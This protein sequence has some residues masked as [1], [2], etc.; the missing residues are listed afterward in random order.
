[1]IDTQKQ[2]E[3]ALQRL[4]TV[5]YGEKANITIT[6][7]P[8]RS[9]GTFAGYIIELENLPDDFTANTPDWNRDNRLNYIINAIDDTRLQA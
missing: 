7:K 5:L 4:M 6:L 1:M 3:A 2:A 9:I 8:G